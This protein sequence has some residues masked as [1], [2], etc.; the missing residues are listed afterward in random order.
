MEGGGGKL[1]A[2]FSARECSLIQLRHPVS[3]KW[4]ERRQLASEADF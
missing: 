1:A 3:E 4:P 2:S